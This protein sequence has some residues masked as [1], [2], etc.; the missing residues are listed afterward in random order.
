MTE[1]QKLGI[2]NLEETLVASFS[3]TKKLAPI[4]ADGFS[5]QDIIDSFVAINSDAVLKAEIEAALKDIHE[6]PA[7]AKD[8]DMSEIAQ[9][10]ILA[11]KEVPELIEA[12]K[13][14][15]APEVA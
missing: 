6:V 5:L 11:V 14:P 1:A 13:K 10:I 9:L 12:F 7:E 3:L 4:Y 15:E 8:L 2:K